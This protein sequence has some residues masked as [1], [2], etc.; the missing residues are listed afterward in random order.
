MLSSIE[1]NYKV[2]IGV[3]YEAIWLTS[4]LGELNLQQT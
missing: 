3:T 2:A 1:V 4:S